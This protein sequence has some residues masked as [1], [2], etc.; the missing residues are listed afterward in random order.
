MTMIGAIR[1][2]Y[3]RSD[4]LLKDRCHLSASQVE[5]MQVIKANPGKTQSEIS[6]LADVD[7]TT[8]GRLLN[9][10]V[11]A[12]WVELAPRDGRT[13]VATLTDRGKNKLKTVERAIAQM[14]LDAAAVLGL[15]QIP[16]LTR[17]LD[18][19]AA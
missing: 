8:T 13:N 3:R 18:A 4:R 12:G 9:R 1:G 17:V 11:K 15:K 2:A 16:E 7:M 19:F 6:S 5:I 10:F 14:E